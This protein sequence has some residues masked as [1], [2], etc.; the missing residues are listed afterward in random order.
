MCPDFSAA[1]GVQNQNPRATR[2]FKRSVNLILGVQ[3][4]ELVCQPRQKTT[5]LVLNELNRH[6]LGQSFISSFG[7]FVLVYKPLLGGT[8][9]LV[10][11]LFVPVFISHQRSLRTGMFIYHLLEYPAHRR[12]LID[13]HC[14]VQG[15][16]V[17]LNSIWL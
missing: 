3:E 10:L 5:K 7:A 13:A 8:Q 12:G 9:C 6:R 11:Q 2:F 4:D 15:A 17:Q 1:M 14:S 16:H